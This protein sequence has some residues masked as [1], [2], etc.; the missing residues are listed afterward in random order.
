MV[1]SFRTESYFLLDK[2]TK[3]NTKSGGDAGKKTQNYR[4]AQWSIDPLTKYANFDFSQRGVQPIW[5]KL[6]LTI[7]W[8]LIGLGSQQVHIFWLIDTVV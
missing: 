8:P 7:S 1:T 6:N 2:W 3:I 5:N 4:T